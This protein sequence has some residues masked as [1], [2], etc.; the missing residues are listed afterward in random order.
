MLCISRY[1]KASIM[2][3]LVVTEPTDSE[4]KIFLCP[5]AS[6]LTPLSLWLFLEAKPQRNKN[7]TTTAAKRAKTRERKVA[8]SIMIFGYFEDILSTSHLEVTY[9]I[10]STK[11]N[12]RLF[13]FRIGFIFFLPYGPGKNANVL[14]KKSLKLILDLFFETKQQFVLFFLRFPSPQQTKNQAFAFSPSACETRFSPR[15][16]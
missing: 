13:F 10:T 4:K 9:G 11:T 7:K 1:G 3:F 6:P 16:S 15:H 8:G 5:H 12:F 2:G 14:S